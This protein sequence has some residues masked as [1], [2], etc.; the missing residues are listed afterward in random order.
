MLPIVSRVPGTTAD[1]AELV[2]ATTSHVVA[3][4]GLLNHCLALSALPVVQILLKK[5]QLLPFAAPSVHI[6]QAFAAELSPALV[7]LEHPFV[8]AFESTHA[9]AIFSRTQT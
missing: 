6:Q 3:S 8:F 2:A 4:L 9:L 5:V 7:T 1:V